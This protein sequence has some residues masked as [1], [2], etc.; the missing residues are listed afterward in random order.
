MS[1]VCTSCKQWHCLPCFSK[2]PLQGRLYHA[3]PQVTEIMSPTAQKQICFQSLTTYTALLSRD[4]G[5]FAY[6]S[7]DLF[8]SSLISVILSYSTSHYL[9]KCHLAHFASTCRNLRSVGSFR[10]CRY[11]RHSLSDLG[12]WCPLPLPMNC[13]RLISELRPKSYISSTS[14]S[15]TV[16]S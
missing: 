13:N 1:C 3:R 8:L 10:K 5:M 9:S 11:S 6:C 12:F 16:I 14:I 2:L 15:E 7:L 4:K